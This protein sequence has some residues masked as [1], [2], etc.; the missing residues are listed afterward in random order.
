MTQL[1]LDL[2]A[3]GENSNA[4]MFHI[5]GSPKVLLWPGDEIRM[6]HDRVSGGTWLTQATIYGCCSAKCPVCNPEPYRCAYG[7]CPPKW[8]D[9]SES[10]G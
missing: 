7:C 2:E 3:A 4:W 10:R 9:S 6:M 8:V 5:D 1:S